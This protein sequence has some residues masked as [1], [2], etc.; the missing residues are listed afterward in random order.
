M[1]GAAMDRV[2]AAA[3]ADYAQLGGTGE[4][5]YRSLGEALRALWM[6]TRGLVREHAILF[7]LEAQRAGMHLAYLLAAVL[8]ASVLAVT[9]WL[10]IVVAIIVWL[11]SEDV[12]WPGVLLIAAFLNLL[13]AAAVAWWARKQ[14]GE[15]P[16]SAT[17]RQLSADR[18]E[19]TVSGNH[20]HTTRP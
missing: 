7:V 19:I 18:H 3:G 2:R 6:D 16:F 9:A 4:A 14:V 1:A 20:A 12:P 8:V 17:L 13:A 10:A 5:G 11:A 15:K